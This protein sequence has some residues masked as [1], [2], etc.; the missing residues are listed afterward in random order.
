M[1]EKELAEF[2]SRDYKEEFERTFTR[3]AYSR[4]LYDGHSEKHNAVFRK[5]QSCLIWKYD[6]FKYIGELLKLDSSFYRA[7]GYTSIKQ[8]TCQYCR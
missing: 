3:V 4:D 8:F 7:G 1:S 5:L 6:T 2:T